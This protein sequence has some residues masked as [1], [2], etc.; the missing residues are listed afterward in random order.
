MKYS[1]RVWFG[2][3]RHQR[4]M[5]RFRYGPGFIAGTAGFRGTQG[6][7]SHGLVNTGEPTGPAGPVIPVSI[8]LKSAADGRRPRS[9]VRWLPAKYL[10]L[11][12]LLRN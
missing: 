12:P 3:A 8:P 5:R 1:P 4:L 2:F 9:S 7:P 6:S 10:H 11:A